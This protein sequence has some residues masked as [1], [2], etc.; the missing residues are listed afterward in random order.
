M[1]AIGLPLADVRSL[2]AGY[3]GRI[4]VAAINSPE[5]TAISG[6]A[7]DVD[8]LVT[9]LTA[10]GVFARALRGDF[11]FH[12]RHMDPFIDELKQVLGGIR[13]TPASIALF[14]T[15]TGELNAGR[16]PGDCDSG[17]WARNMRD[18]VLF[19]PAI[20]R[21]SGE[22]FPV[23]LE[24]GPHPVL[25]SDIQQALRK[26]GQKAFALPSLE[27]GKDERQTLL[28]SLGHLHVLGYPVAWRELCPGGRPI[29]LPAY[30]WQRE[31]FWLSSQA[32][33]VSTQA[34]A[35]PAIDGGKPSEPRREERK[36]ES[37]SSACSERPDLASALVQSV[38]TVLGYAP[39]RIERNR[40]LLGLGLDSLSAF[41]LKAQIEADLGV[42]IAVTELLRSASVEALAASVKARAAAASGGTAQAVGAAPPP[43]K[44]SVVDAIAAT[45]GY[46]PDRVDLA[47]SLVRLG[48]DSLL[49]FKLKARIDE[50][51]K[52]SL[53]VSELLRNRS[54][55]ELIEKVEGL[56][57]AI[58]SDRR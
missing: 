7:A 58:E 41:R 34:A 57:G 15:V 6:D 40:P 18:P 22:E 47:D 12:S 39:D 44:T 24:I 28:G 50:S 56:S 36:S 29:P 10:K 16:R 2:I 51:L 32:P 54:V 3:G 42:S 27:R 55:K 19:G 4:E 11:A 5:S 45:L 13:V 9:R 43:V 1:A 21:M 20:E 37:P 46:S 53:P 49:A 14:S 30:P 26:K 25:T 48:I 35:L 31:R 8:D 38:A 33:V 17:Y 52:I 23:F